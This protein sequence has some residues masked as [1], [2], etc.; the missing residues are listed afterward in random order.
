MSGE[1]LKFFHDNFEQQKD[2][3]IEQSENEL[4]F[5]EQS[6]KESEYSLQLIIHQQQET[7]NK[8]KN[9]TELKESH[10]K[11]ATKIRVIMSYNTFIFSMY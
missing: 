10:L 4:H 1:R 3:L 2:A 11:N 5:I 8:Y 9:E 6:Q 7:M